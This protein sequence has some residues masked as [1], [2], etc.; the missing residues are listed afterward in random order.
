MVSQSMDVIDAWLSSTLGQA[1]P[2]V[3]GRVLLAVNSSAHVDAL[4]GTLR[5]SV[6]PDS[7]ARYLLHPEAFKIFSCAAGNPF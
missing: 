2:R 5:A 3:S 6:H 1:A 4:R 7:E